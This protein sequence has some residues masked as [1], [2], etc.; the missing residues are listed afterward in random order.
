MRFLQF[1]IQ[2]FNYIYPILIKYM[3]T[4]F[5][6]LN[7]GGMKYHQWNLLFSSSFLETLIKIAY[8][9]SPGRSPGSQSQT[10]P[11]VG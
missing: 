2:N 1:D 6:T 11:F 10:K 7:L 9:H 4:S 5:T 3:V 8:T